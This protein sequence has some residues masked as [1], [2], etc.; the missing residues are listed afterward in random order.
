MDRGLAFAEHGLR[1]LSQFRS[2]RRRDQLILL[3]ALCLVTVIRAGLKVLSLPRIVRLVQHPLPLGPSSITPQRVQ[4]AVTTVSRYVPGA[5]CLTQAL[6]AQA[7]LT[8]AGLRA[9]LRIGVAKQGGNLA[10]HAW[11]EREGAL[12]FGDSQPEYFTPLPHLPIGRHVSD[13]S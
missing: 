9:D 7:L 1:A 13:E 10:A 2:L 6:A 11:L 3:Q 12:I 8:S 5:A 4:W